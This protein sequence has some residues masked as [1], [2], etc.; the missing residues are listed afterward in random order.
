MEAERRKSIVAALLAVHSGR[1]SPDQAARFLEDPGK[2]QESLRGLDGG[3]PVITLSGGNGE[4]GQYDLLAVVEDEEKSRRALAEIGIEE[5]A[6]DTLFSFGAQGGTQGMTVLRDA[7]TAVA[8]SGARLTQ[9]DMK[10]GSEPRPGSENPTQPPK[11]DTRALRLTTDRFLPNFG[12]SAERYDV[13]KEHAR[14][15][16]GRVLLVRDKA[17]GRDIAMKELLPGV[18]SSHSIPAGGS[19]S[20]GVIERFLR[21]A[22]ITGQLEHPNIVPVYEIGKHSD[23]SVYYTMRFVRG[24]TLAEKLREIRK[25]ESLDRKQRLAARIT[26][27]DRFLD[28][29]DAI[30]YA[31]SKGVIHR[32]LKPENIM[33]GEYG[34][35]LVLDWGLA[36]VKGQEDKALRELQKGSMALSR[37]LVES[38]SQN[39]TQDGSIVGTPAYMPPEQARGELE[40]VDEQSD[41]YALG[42]VLYQLLCGSPPYEGPMAGLIVQQVLAG[43]PLRLTAREPDVPPELGALVEKAMA[44]EKA[45][46][47]RTV[48]EL[49]T[50]IKAFR[51]GRTLGVYSY[52]A[53]EMI[54]RFVRQHRTAVSI[55]VLAALI[56]AAGA[57]VAWQQVTRERDDARA[58]HQA[59]ETQRLLAQANLDRAEREKT[60]RERLE[61]EAIR[62]AEEELK[63]RLGDVRRLRATIEGMRVDQILADL[64]ARNGQYEAQAAESGQPF[65][66][67]G[68]EERTGNG[69]LLSSIMGYVSS[70]QNLMDLLSGPAGAALPEELRHIDLVAGRLELQTVRLAAARLAT[71]NGDFPLAE[72][73]LSGVE[74]AAARQARASVESARAGLLALHGRRI[75]EALYDVRADLRREGR[76]A[77]APRLDDYVRLL[78]SYRERET[79]ARL[80]EPARELRLR[81][82][83]PLF[84]WQ[85]ADLDVARLVCRVLGAMEQPKETVPLLAQLLD[86]AGH[87][88]IVREAAGALCATKSAEAID[89]LL[90]QARRRG[91]DFWKQVESGAGRLPLS[92]RLRHPQGVEDWVD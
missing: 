82:L 64:A 23:N 60:E 25:D 80:A 3:V 31:H 85:A 47:M 70:Q 48:R 90:A 75:D 43:P 35:T 2:V 41:V 78:S 7:L 26:L 37:S 65:L 1:I 27:L 15:G 68:L 53:R 45:D 5:R 61:K 19:G 63:G 12:V 6:Q 18:G 67:L 29:C 40:Q 73:M 22:K 77:G 87:P 13:R 44:R 54:A 91:L 36:R 74:D 49:A 62:R 84:V 14:G 20:G 38:D 52:S 32:D 92:E 16:M 51:D 83:N 39:L 9:S 58:A 33:L 69:V 34:E 59:A 8:G 57:I 28:I 17:I 72:L 66:E 21:E 79:V 89:P 24:M 71:F 42:A 76:P 46:R 50:E 81:C 4:A 30:S 56:L 10:A 86:A 11:E 88:V 55:G